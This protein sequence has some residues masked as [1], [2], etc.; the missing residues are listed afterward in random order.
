[1]WSSGNRLDS[2]SS[3]GGPNKVS[4]AN[5]R[6][7][8]C[9]FVRWQ[10][11]TASMDYGSGVSTQEITRI[12]SA[13]MSERAERRGMPSRFHKM[14]SLHEARL[15]AYVRQLRQREAGDYPCS[16]ILTTDHH[17]PRVVSSFPDIFSWMS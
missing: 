2:V 12:Q 16:W 11:R 17:L 13:I 15:L 1:M 10:A 7:V 6:R 4:R 14:L 5:K 8:C 9:G 3:S